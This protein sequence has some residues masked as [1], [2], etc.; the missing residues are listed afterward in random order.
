MKLSHE[1]T[2]ISHG[3]TI[4]FGK[5]WLREISYLN[6]LWIM[7]NCKAIMIDYDVSVMTW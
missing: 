7:E 5:C 2:K 6:S 3:L 1:M 4:N